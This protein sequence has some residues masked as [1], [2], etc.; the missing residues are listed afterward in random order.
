MNQV[1][2]VTKLDHKRGTI[3]EPLDTTDVMWYKFKTTNGFIAI[4]VDGDGYLRLNAPEGYLTILPISAN[5]LRVN[6]EPYE[7]YQSDTNS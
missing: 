3:D 1:V 5:S 6:V 4:S 7:K 2:S